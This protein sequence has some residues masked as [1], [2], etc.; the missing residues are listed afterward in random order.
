MLASHDPCSRLTLPESR[1]PRC[2][3]SSTGFLVAVVF[4]L[5]ASA[6]GQDATENSDTGK[7]L[8][9]TSVDSA[10][11]TSPPV[12]DTREEIQESGAVI[13][14]IFDPK[15]VA[16]SSSGPD[17]LVAVGNSADNGNFKVATSVDGIQWTS[18]DGQISG[19]PDE[20]SPRELWNFGNGHLLLADNLLPTTPGLDTEPII[21]TSDDLQTWKQLDLDGI[22][23]EFLNGLP[24]KYSTVDVAGDGS[25]AVLTDRRG[26]VT[27]WTV[28]P[29]DEQPT[30]ISY[31]N[32]ENIYDVTSVGENIVGWAAID[33]SYFT[34]DGLRT[35]G[36]IDYEVYILN[37][38]DW[39]SVTLP[40]VDTSLEPLL[41]SVGNRLLYLTPDET[42]ST[43]DLGDTWTQTA[44]LPAQT[45][46]KALFE[47]FAAAGPAFPLD[48]TPEYFEISA[49]GTD[50]SRIPLPAEVVE[51][52]HLATT[53]DSVL[54]L[55]TY[56]NPD[57]DEILRTSLPEP[58]DE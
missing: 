41:K 24:D 13:G 48:G 35:Q 14:E 19:L 21:A 30:A 45:H 20:I 52:E 37:G 57:R 28:R 2:G 40:A 15:T 9:P 46:A 5:V 47:N 22:D 29:G 3:A 31:S 17:A 44:T 38:L 18:A 10:S 53:P 55:I 27:L 4:A 39:Q 49:N 36:E 54:S 23:P 43:D 34:S 50:W 25:V 32:R 8:T 58:G 16:V 7:S 6:C 12:A 56:S 51:I 42:W 11:V 1:Q 26:S 33:N